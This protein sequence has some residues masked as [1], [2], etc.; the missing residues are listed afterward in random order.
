MNNQKDDELAKKNQ[1]REDLLR[2][3]ELDTLA[4]VRICDRLKEI[5]FK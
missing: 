3:Y 4:M 5:S 1:I 2:Y